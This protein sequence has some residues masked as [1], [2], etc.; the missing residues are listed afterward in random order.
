MKIQVR[1]PTKGRV[2]NQRTLKS[3]PIEFF[4]AYDT[5]LVCPVS[6][7]E[8]LRKSVPSVVSVIGTAAQNDGIRGTRNFIL[9]S[10]AEEGAIVLMLDDDIRGWCGRVM[11]HTKARY[12]RVF[13]EDVMKNFK[14][15]F[16]HFSLMNSVHASF[17]NRL[18]ANNRDGIGRPG[19]MRTAIAINA[20]RV[21][22]LGVRY[23]L[24]VMEDLDVQLQLLKLGQEPFEFNRMVWDDGLSQMSAG[25]CS[26]FLDTKLQQACAE[27]LARF[28]PGL[29]SVTHRK[30]GWPTVKVAWKRALHSASKVAAVK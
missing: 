25:G 22:E 27:D 17:G 14:E 10:A 26:T 24:P 8:S 19:L 4:E 13:G 5:A 15:F 28:H 20:P 11:Y 7:V 12:G 6:E 23:R 30:D 2:G 18:F 16:E 9:E 1:I 3:L 21:V 29:V